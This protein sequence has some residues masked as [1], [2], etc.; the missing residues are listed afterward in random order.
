MANTN[1][2]YNNEA[3]A[4]TALAYCFN[5]LKVVEYSKVFLILPFV[6]HEPTA[7]RLRGQTNKRSLEEFIVKAPECFITFN[8][9]YQDFLTLTINSII[10]LYEA[11][12]ISIKNDL[13]YFNNQANYSP[14]ESRSSSNRAENIQKALDSLCLLFGTES[15]SSFYLKLKVQL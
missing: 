3:I 1:S 8:A 9:R 5:E 6:L 13:I 2:L 10:I 7:R 12:V 14:F 15:T 11:N 4:S